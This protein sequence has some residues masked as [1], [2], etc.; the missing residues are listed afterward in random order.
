MRRGVDGLALLRQQGLDV[1][2]VFGGG[3]GEAVA[4]GAFRLCR[5][6]GLAR[7][8]HQGLGIL[9]L[10]ALGDGRF[11]DGFFFIAVEQRLDFLQQFATLFGAVGD[12][13]GKHVGQRFIRAFGDH[14]GARD[15]RIDQHVPVRY[16]AFLG[17]RFF[18]HLP[19]RFGIHM[20]A[21]QRVRGGDHGQQQHQ[22]EACSQARA[23]TKVGEGVHGWS[24]CRRGDLIACAT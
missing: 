12:G 16:E 6:A 1:V 23:D 8:H 2:L 11:E 5:V 22:R 17:Q 9:V 20:G 13:V 10:D 18:H 7:I 15:G 21:V 4:V 24:S 19:R 3:R 14:R